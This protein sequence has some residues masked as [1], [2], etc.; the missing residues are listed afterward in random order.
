MK[1]T[2]ICLLLMLIPAAVFSQTQ[3][4]NVFRENVSIFGNMKIGYRQSTGNVSS[5]GSDVKFEE[6][7]A[8]NIYKN[9]MA[10]GVNLGINIY[11]VIVS[12]N[13]EG[14]L[15]PYTSRGQQYA[16]LKNPAWS[17]VK[18]EY[19]AFEIFGG[20]YFYSGSLIALY[21]GLSYGS[22]DMQY[23]KE[24]ESPINEDYNTAAVTLG[25]QIH[26]FESKDVYL[27][28]NIKYCYYVSGHTV[29]KD[30]IIYTGVGYKIPLF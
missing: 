10:F 7:K 12:L 2:L 8:S 14:G 23:Y 11:P 24:G 1:K 22:I 17:N 18:S 4:D 13:I 15:L 16:N 3:S 27:L 5:L 9:S 20:Y 29:P 30:F 25:F 28:G 6:T 26:P 21:A 19:A